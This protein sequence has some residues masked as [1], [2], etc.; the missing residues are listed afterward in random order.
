MTRRDTLIQPAGDSMMHHLTAWSDNGV[1]RK[2]SA[3]DTNS[4]GN[5]GET[6]VWFA[7][8]DVAVIQTV[9]E[10]FAFDEAAIVLWT[11]GSFNPRTDVTQQMTMDRQS[12]LIAQVRAWL[13]VFGIPLP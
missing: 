4:T 3:V 6:D 7:A 11:D 1:I 13:A 9:S 2:L 12:A 10:I 8:G 5:Q